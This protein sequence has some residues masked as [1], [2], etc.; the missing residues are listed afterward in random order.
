[1]NIF[2][3]ILETLSDLWSNGYIRLATVLL[4]VGFVPFY[5]LSMVQA[6]LV[7]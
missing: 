1:M 2:T 6:Q 7:R 3:T 4:A 5:F